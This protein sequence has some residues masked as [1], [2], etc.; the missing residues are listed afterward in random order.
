MRRIGDLLALSCA[1]VLR[2]W[3]DSVLSDGWMAGAVSFSTLFGSSWL[4]LQLTKWVWM[5]F[6]FS[7]M[8][9]VVVSSGWVSMLCV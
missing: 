6:M 7:L 3:C 4:V 8:V 9:S 2:V 1:R 5:S